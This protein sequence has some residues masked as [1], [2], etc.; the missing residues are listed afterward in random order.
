MLI[1]TLEQKHKGFKVAPVACRLVRS[2]YEFATRDLAPVST[3][4]AAET[5]FQ[6]KGNPINMMHDCNLSF[7]DANAKLAAVRK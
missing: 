3:A 4:V 1:I 7:A 5:H 6:K 2:S